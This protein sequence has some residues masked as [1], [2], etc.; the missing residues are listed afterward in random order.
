M[1]E[2]SL[3]LRPPALRPGDVI[4][5]AA[6]AKPVEADTVRRIER[7]LEALGYRVRFAP[8]VTERWGY[9]AGDDETRARSLSELQSDPEIRAVFCAAGGYGSTRILDRIDYR[10]FAEDPKIFVGYSDIT[11]LHAAVGG[12]TGL[13]TFHAPMPMTFLGWEKTPPDPRTETVFWETLQGRRGKGAVIA[14]ESDD[15]EPVLRVPGRARGRL[16]GGNLSLLCAL[17]GT[18][19][20]VPSRDRILFL[21][22]VGEEPYRIDRYLSQLRL[23]GKL[24]DA[25]GILLGSWS[26]CSPESPE[27]SLSIREVLRDYFADSPVP[28]L[29]GFP[30]GHRR[31]NMTLPLGIRVELD[32][33]AG[34]LRFLED[35]TTPPAAGGDSD[36]A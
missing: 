12:E 10:I 22:D 21:E 20:E 18:P 9:L 32:A 31:R 7:R 8:G 1:Q 3:P 30:A 19:W 24:R 29:A 33:D 34:V 25:A 14:A 13:V 26:R 36:P 11:A 28:V 6:P 4:G 35:P 5:I 23:A 27:R 2:E 15:A 16:A 17:M